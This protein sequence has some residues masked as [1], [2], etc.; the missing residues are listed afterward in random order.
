MGL[1]RILRDDCASLTEQPNRVWACDFLTDRMHG[2]HTLR[3]LT[4]V[5]ECTREALAI[6]VAGQVSAD[7]VLAT[8]TDLCITRGWQ[9]HL[10]SDNGPEVCAKGARKWFPWLEVCTLFIEIS[11][12]C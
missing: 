9:A 10:R 7:D 11:K 5:D 8:L 1:A 6:V 2:G 3:L 4:I 12:G